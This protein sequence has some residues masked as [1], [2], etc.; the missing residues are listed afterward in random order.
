MTSLDRECRGQQKSEW[1][2]RPACRRKE[3]RKTWPCGRTAPAWHFQRSGLTKKPMA[4]F[5]TFAVEFNLSSVASTFNCSVNPGCRY[6]KRV[7]MLYALPDL[8]FFFKHTYFSRFSCRRPY[9]NHAQFV[10]FATSAPFHTHRLCLSLWRCV[11]VCIFA[12]ISQI[13][14]E[15][16]L[17]N[18]HGT[19]F[20]PPDFWTKKWGDTKN[21]G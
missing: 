3:R 14:F 9:Q 6:L 4:S 21:S 19:L 16:S 10:S 1:W 12:L 2:R 20:P 15:G 18:R 5:N 8:S 17:S 13:D 11:R 7:S